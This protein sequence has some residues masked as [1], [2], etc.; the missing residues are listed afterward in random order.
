MKD[1]C[2]LKSYI[3]KKIGTKK[4]SERIS[5]LHCV[6]NYPVD[7]KNVNLNSIPFLKMN[8]NLTIGYSDHSLGSEACIGAVAL[9]AKIIEK[10][11]TLDKNFSIFRD[12]QLSA[13]FNDM[14]KIVKSIRKIESQ[15]GKF[16]KSILAVE[17]KNY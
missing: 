2:T 7:D 6:T 15:L 14:K 13:D 10:H 12:H 9:G 4:M 3:S 11:F 1:I 17:K 5:L 16:N 8:T